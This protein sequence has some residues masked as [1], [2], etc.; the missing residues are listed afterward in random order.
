[1]KYRITRSTKKQQL[2]AL[3]NILKPY[4]TGIE[5][6]RLGGDNDGGYLIPNDLSGI[7][8]CF[9]PGVDVN[10]TFELACA[11][12]GMSVHLADS[13]VERPPV[14][15]PNFSFTSSHVGGFSRP[16]FLDFAEWVEKN[17]PTNGDLLLQMDIEGCEY[18]VLSALSASLISCFRIIVIEFHGLDRLL[19]R[20]FYDLVMPMFKK[21][22]MSHVCVHIHPNN[23]H[24]VSSNH[25][26][27]VPKLAEFTLLRR[28]R[29]ISLS[30]ANVFP[31][32]L[33]Q[34]CC[35]NRTLV[36]PK[37]WYSR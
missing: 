22:L 9:S 21:L 6:I 33:D 29:I 4:N 1:M 13:S 36:L 31:H 2:E 23:Y 20:S 18:E 34:D 35:K 14:S 32:P 16:G 11:N 12:L 8:C 10:S 30:P 28:D 5:L 24:G 3:L 26:I 17:S 7:N 15:H 37:C 19:E 27:E 25:G